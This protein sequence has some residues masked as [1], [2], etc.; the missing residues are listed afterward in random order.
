MPVRSLS[1]LVLKWPRAAEVARAAHA[2]AAREA[3][4]QAGLVALGY[5]GSYAT[6]RAGVGSD[7]DLIAIVETSDLPYERRALS[8]NLESLPVPAEILVYTQR[9]WESMRSEGARFVKAIE[10]DTVW[11]WRT[12]HPNPQ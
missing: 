8:W 2:W 9:E 7:L 11:L 5:F 1:S 3:P 4:C 6:G 10:R 12:S